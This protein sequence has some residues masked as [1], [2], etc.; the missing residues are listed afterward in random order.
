MI[1]PLHSLFNLIELADLDDLFDTNEI[2][3]R[4]NNLINTPFRPTGISLLAVRKRNNRRISVSDVAN[5]KCPTRR[6]IYIR[7]N[8]KHIAEKYQKKAA[9]TYGMASDK[10]TTSWSGYFPDNFQTYK[11]IDAIKDRIIRQ[12]V[13]ENSS[14]FKQMRNLDDKSIN[15]E[16]SSSS[17]LIPKKW[18]IRI[19]VA[20]LKK[21]LAYQKLYNSL[22]TKGNNKF[23]TEDELKAKSKKVKDE[24]N[25]LL[26]KESVPDFFVERAN[27]VG[28]VKTGL[29]LNKSHL[30]T[31]AGYALLLESLFNYH[32]NWG[33]IYLITTRKFSFSNIFTTGQIYLIPITDDLRKDFISAR[34]AA[35]ESLASDQIPQLPSKE[36]R[37]NICQS[38]DFYRFCWND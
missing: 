17:A 31:V 34:D 18:M 30:L 11:E 33:A 20:N 28:D 26:S 13:K 16:E 37:N 1:G 10:L 6:D 25:V 15:D 22:G 14:I 12:V 38:C 5:S 7:K 8:K 4:G 35:Y 36:E 3:L 24:W 2:Q 9:K 27:L 21:E 29:F 19:L 32:I 23:L